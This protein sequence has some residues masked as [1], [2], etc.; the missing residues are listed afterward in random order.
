MGLACLG[1]LLTLKC[2]NQ[3]LTVG[4]QYHSRFLELFGFKF[5][6]GKHPSFHKMAESAEGS[7]SRA[8]E[9]DRSLRQRARETGKLTAWR[10]T[11][12]IGLASCDAMKY[13]IPALEILA[14]H[15]TA[16]TDLPK[17]VPIALVRSEVGYTSK[18]GFLTIFLRYTFR[19]NI[20]E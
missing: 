19:R 4:F 14:R 3:D 9:A 11:K 6:E 10:N 7:L 18:L 17:A 13:N 8:W 20:Y 2:G 5:L 12:L 15:W 16:M 1:Q